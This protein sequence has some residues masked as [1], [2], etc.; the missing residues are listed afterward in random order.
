MRSIGRDSITAAMSSQPSRIR[1][2]QEPSQPK[3]VTKTR[4]LPS[5][6]GRAQTARH[7]P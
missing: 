7:A 5:S 1:P 3:A 6:V 2:D 4:T